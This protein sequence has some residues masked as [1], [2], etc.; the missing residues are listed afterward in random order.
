MQTD[1]LAKWVFNHSCGQEDY[2][3]IAKYIFDNPN[4]WEKD[5]ENPNKK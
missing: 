4:N 1:N 5:E 2:E 3:R